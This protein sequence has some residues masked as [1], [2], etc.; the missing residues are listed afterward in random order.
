M[1]SA[2]PPGHTETEYLIGLAKKYPHFKCIEGQ[3]HTHTQSAP[4]YKII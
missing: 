1:A 4:Y 2:A 3:T